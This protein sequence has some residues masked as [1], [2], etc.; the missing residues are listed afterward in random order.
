MNY[1]TTQKRNVPI[2]IQIKKMEETIAELKKDINE[3]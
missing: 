3:Q 1:E 2:K